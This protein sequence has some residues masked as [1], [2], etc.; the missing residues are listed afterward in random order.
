MRIGIVTASYPSQVQPAD[1][2]FVRQ[3]VR[4]LARQGHDCTVIQPVTLLNRLR[5]QLPGRREEERAGDRV[6]AVHRPRFL[7]FSSRDL[8]FTHTRRWSNRTFAAA[9]RREI[10]RRRME[11]DVVYGHFLYPAGHAAVLAAR[12]LKVPSV[13]A[14]GEGEF[15][16]VTPV[17]FPRAA[18][19]MREATAFLAVATRLADEL[20]ERLEVPRSK[21]RVF[22][23]GVDRDLFHPRDRAECGRRLGLDPAFFHVGFVGPFVETKGFPQ[24]VEAASGLDGVRLVLL[25]RGAQ[26][27][28]GAAV[29]FCGEV[30]HDSVPDYLCACDA[31][32]LP[33]RIEG[34]C[35]SVIEA[36][37]CGL[38]IVTS[39][40]RHMD[41]IVDDETAIRVDP[42]D[43][44]A[45]R[46][47]IQRLRG[48]PVLRRRM[49]QAAL[50]KSRQFDIQERA[51]R[52]AVWM[53]DLAGGVSG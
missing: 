13:V 7:S 18:A 27:P 24:L 2:T 34:S 12:D 52:V 14:V 16:T 46:A 20:V 35:N 50:E 25:G 6:I 29:A 38:P 43:P 41:D 31:F 19:H 53:Q 42:R 37:A 22:P 1:G 45:I 39:I 10:R 17:G 48:D 32:V 4:A 30:E 15:W 49:A 26:P 3:F 36:M 9:V 5:G 23:N 21:I 44:A 47:A 33:T 11:L 8:G 28:A 51:Q 40:G